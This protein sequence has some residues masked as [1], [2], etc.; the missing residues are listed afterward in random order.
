M[1]NI[2]KL[3]KEQGNQ[4]DWSQIVID[5]SELPCFKPEAE[6]PVPSF[7]AEPDLAEFL[8][9]GYV[10]VS[11]SISRTSYHVIA[12]QTG[13]SPSA[14]IVNGSPAFVDC[15]PITIE[16]V[17]PSSAVPAIVIGAASRTAF[18]YVP[19]FGV[20]DDSV[21]MPVCALMSAGGVETWYVGY[22]HPLLS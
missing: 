3:M 11:Y 20:S 14:S 8:S 15:E 4:F 6:W 5:L 18:S 17:I 10:V 1:K 19:V 7:P 21:M 16:P 2:V 12:K 22:S 9:D 13:D